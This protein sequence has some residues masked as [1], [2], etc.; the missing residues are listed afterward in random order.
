MVAISALD[1]Y[2]V[3]RNILR[4]VD[5]A[6]ATLIVREAGGFVR[7]MTGDDLDMEFDLIGRTSVL[8]G[9]SETLLKDILPKA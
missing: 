9:C 6:A 3:G 1:Y 7:T 8:A 5:I 4:I 2:Y